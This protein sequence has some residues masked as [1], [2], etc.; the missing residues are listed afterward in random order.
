MHTIVVG[1]PDNVTKIL[2]PYRKKY[3][4]ASSQIFPHISLLKPFSFSGK[5]T[6]LHQHLEEIADIQAPIKVSTIAWDVITDKRHW[7][8]LP[9]VRG[10]DEFTSLYQDLVTGQLRPL[11]TQNSTYQAKILFGNFNNSEDLDKAK[12]DLKRFEPRFSFRVTK[13]ALL[14]RESTAEVWQIEKEFG[15]KGTIK[16][17]P[18]NNQ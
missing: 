17:V 8:C 4:P 14:Y 6:K 10:Q 2:A 16:S 1:V 5:T 12:K 13:M 3:D 18:R 7:L 9:L 11:A 15:F